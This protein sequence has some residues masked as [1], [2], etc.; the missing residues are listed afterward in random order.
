MQTGTEF[1]LPMLNAGMTFF[2]NPTK[3]GHATRQTGEFELS[4][5]KPFNFVIFPVTGHPSEL[6]VFGLMYKLPS[7]PFTSQSPSIAS[8]APPL[9]SPQLIHLRNS[10]L[11]L[12]ILAFLVAVSLRLPLSSAPLPFHCLH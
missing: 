11:E 8:L 3:F 4:S 6:H 7:P 12:D 2:I 5:S 1:C 10:L 9:C